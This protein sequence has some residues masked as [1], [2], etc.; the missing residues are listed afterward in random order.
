MKLINSVVIATSELV[1][2]VIPLEIK[3]ELK[4]ELIVRDGYRCNKRYGFGCGCTRDLTIDHIIPISMGGPICD[5]SNLQFLC[6]KCHKKKTNRC[7]RKLIFKRF[8]LKQPPSIE[9]IEDSL[10][11]NPYARQS[12]CKIRV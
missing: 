7:D 10:V 2:N 3:Y 8:F 4:F 1:W 9:H 11:R 12:H 6:E 5:V